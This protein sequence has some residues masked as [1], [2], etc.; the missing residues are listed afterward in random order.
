MARAGRRPRA[1]ARAARRPPD[2]A[3][4]RRSR[5]VSALVN[6]P[7]RTWKVRPRASRESV[8]PQLAERGSRAPRRPR[9][10]PG[11]QRGPSTTTM[12]MAS[13]SSWPTG[14]VDLV[15]DR[16]P[17]ARRRT[18]RARRAGRR[19]SRCLTT[20]T[21]RTAPTRGSKRSRTTSSCWLPNARLVRVDDRSE[22]GSA[23]CSSAT[24]RSRASRERQRVE[25]ELLVARPSPRWPS[26]SRPWPGPRIR[27]IGEEVSSTA[28]TRSSGAVS[29]LR[30]SSPRCSSICV[31]VIRKRVVRKRITPS[32]TGIATPT[33]CHQLRSLLLPR[34]KMPISTGRNLIS[35]CTGLTSSIRGS[36][37][38]HS[39]SADRGPG[40][41]VPERRSD[42]LGSG[43][44]W[45]TSRPP[46]LLP[47][48]G[49][50]RRPTGRP[51]ACR[52][53]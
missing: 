6:S 34:T 39:A 44:R 13:R 20:S 25:D 15:E 4:A 46:P 37:R 19:R 38:R 27:W 2:R 35:S 42:W 48:D 8:K 40:G 49:S 28:R 52:S 33:S 24:R 32:A 5:L 16:A 9:R 29:T 41:T 50:G 17:D 45:V 7:R 36:S 23:R 22:G 47:Y 18:G 43:R 51:P 12:A 26:R 10:G 21:A 11:T 1:A 30:P 31:G 14:H 53:R 3:P